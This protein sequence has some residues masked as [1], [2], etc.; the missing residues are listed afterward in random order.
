MVNP[1]GNN[2]HD[3]FFANYGKA[4]KKPEPV[5]E[6]SSS[7]ARQ[8]VDP[9]KWLDENKRFLSLDTIQAK[10]DF[11]L[12]FIN[13][14]TSSP[15]IDGI[16]DEVN[17]RLEEKS[18]SRIEN[19]THPNSE[20]YELVK[21]K[22]Y[23][24]V[25]QNPNFKILYS[26]P[27]QNYKNSKK[28]VILIG[29]D[30][31]NSQLATQQFQLLKELYLDGDLA[32]SSSFNES[33]TSAE[34]ALSSIPKGLSLDQ[35]QKSIIQQRMAKETA[36]LYDLRTNQA[37]TAS[38]PYLGYNPEV[39]S[40]A[41]NLDVMTA[42]L[43]VIGSGLAAR[44]NDPNQQVFNSLSYE[45]HKINLMKLTYEHIDLKHEFYALLGARLKHAAKEAG[46]DEATQRRVIA[47]SI[48]A[49]ERFSESHQ[50]QDGEAWYRKYQQTSLTV[51]QAES[52][53]LYGYALKNTQ[54]HTMKRRDERITSLFEDAD[55]GTRTMII[56]A[57]HYRNPTD[58]KTVLSRLEEKG[59]PVIII[60]G[61]SL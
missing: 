43:L 44:I 18:P 60:E 15:S 54:E 47:S 16:S 29:D 56:G 50:K 22:I 20:R 45:V 31:M 58:G 42:K 46:L 59:I 17:L 26:S 34:S 32:L 27:S 10:I 23:E 7:P 19:K 33:N 39:L 36:L 38:V 9:K 2:P 14:E 3:D 51:D 55:P 41:E 13:Q 6:K 40:Q 1:T 12:S 57:S 5:N 53:K 61:K 30:H 25:A 24:R 49:L 37:Q 4:S 48:E 11:A 21:K 35:I 28:I 8:T 52:E